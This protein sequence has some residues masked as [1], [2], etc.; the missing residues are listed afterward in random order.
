MTVFTDAIKAGYSTVFSV[1]GKAVT[2]Q[3]LSVEG[4]ATLNAIIGRS[5]FD[6]DL[7]VG[8]LTKETRDFIVSSSSLVFDN[9]RY[10]PKVGDRIREVIGATEYTWE[11]YNP[12]QAAVFNYTDADRAF[13]RIHTQLVDSN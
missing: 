11:C 2:F 10:E 8:I 9:A 12:T 3:R 4:T 6:I 13:M 5:T 1:A 7:D